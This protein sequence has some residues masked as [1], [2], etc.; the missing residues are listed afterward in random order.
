MYIFTAVYRRTTICYTKQP[1][2]SL[3]VP[4]ASRIQPFLAAQPFT[5]LLVYLY[6]HIY[7]M[8]LY[9][10]FISLY[11]RLFVLFDFVSECLFI[12]Q[13]LY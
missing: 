12:C 6:G 4:A 7:I 2:Y 3:Q 10:I 8:Q 11:Q 1:P 9:I 5:A 13:C